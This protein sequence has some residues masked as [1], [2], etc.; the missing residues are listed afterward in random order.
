MDFR[1]VGRAHSALLMSISRHRSTSAYS[2]PSTTRS[3]IL[4]PLGS[5]QSPHFWDN[6]HPPSIPLS[7]PKSTGVESCTLANTPSSRIDQFTLF[8]LIL[9]HKVQS[10][11]AFV[12]SIESLLYHR[13][14]TARTGYSSH[15]ACH[16]R[17]ILRSSLTRRLFFHHNSADITT[18][19]Q[20]NSSFCCSPAL[21]HQP[22]PRITANG[23]VRHSATMAST[24]S[25]PGVQ[26]VPDPTPCYNCG[27]TG[28]FFTAC[29]EPTRNPP[30]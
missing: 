7:P 8:L 27:N 3:L 16:I 5:S 23:L 24:A 14:S 21:R 1:S 2:L 6:Q 29:S 15:D 17:Q 9:L 4:S 19:P 11:S 22:L 26:S 20:P 30:L 13:F 10:L 12:S 28:H 18:T 25:A